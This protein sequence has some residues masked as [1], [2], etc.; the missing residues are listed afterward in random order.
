MQVAGSRASEPTRGPSRSEHSPSR[1]F[2]CHRILLSAPPEVTLPPPQ[3]RARPACTWA[4]P[5]H[6]VCPGV[7]AQ[8]GAALSELRL[9]NDSC[10]EGERWR[11]ADSARPRPT[12]ERC[13]SPAEARLQPQPEPASATGSDGPRWPGCPQLRPVKARSLDWSDTPLQP[14]QNQDESHHVSLMSPAARTDS[15]AYHWQ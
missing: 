14:W 2:A 6:P 11:G 10:V 1:L 4:P 3:A 7:V 13:W 5:T 9:E 8:A 12:P 15:M